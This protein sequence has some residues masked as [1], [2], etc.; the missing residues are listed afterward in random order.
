V[1]PPLVVHLGSLKE[2][3]NS[4]E[5]EF[6]PRDL[7]L[8]DCEVAENPS[9]EKIVGPVDI[10]ATILRNGQRYMVRG[11]ISYRARLDCALCGGEFESDFREPLSAEFLSCGA[12]NVDQDEADGDELERIRLQVDSIDLTPMVRDAIH[13]AVPIAPVCRPECRGV[14]PSC[15]ADLNLGPCSCAE[16]VPRRRNV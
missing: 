2:G 3:E 10:R 11:E 1:K 4:F 13:L 16:P 14:C 6:L 12:S 8:T 15:G 9:F 7:G 5:L